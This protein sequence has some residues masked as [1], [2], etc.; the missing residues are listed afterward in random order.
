MRIELESASSGFETKEII[1]KASHLQGLVAHTQLPACVTQSGRE[2]IPYN[3]EL[4]TI[5]AKLIVKIYFRLGA[6]VKEK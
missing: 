6:K 4:L 5:L 1:N 2:L 3:P